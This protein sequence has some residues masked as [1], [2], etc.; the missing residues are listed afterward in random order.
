MSAVDDNNFMRYIYRGEEGEIIPREATHIFVG[1]D[2]TLVRAQAFAN[3]SNIVEVICHENVEKIEEKAFYFCRSLRRVIMSG[4]KIV[5][6]EAFYGC[7]ALTD[8]ECGK[9]EVIKESAFFCCRSLEKINLP[10]ARI[11][12]LWAF[13]HYTQACFASRNC[14]E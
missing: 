8:V 7:A 2:V 5:Q 3:H 11:V 9:L 12:S 10:S 4:V 1:K 6:K 13:N 14:D